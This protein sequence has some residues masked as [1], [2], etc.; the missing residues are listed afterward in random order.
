MRTRVNAPLVAGLSITVFGLLCLN[1]TTDGKADDHR[2]W[3]RE[4]G[5][6]EPG[7]GIYLLGLS[8]AVGGAGLAG[9]VIGRRRASGPA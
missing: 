1:Y 7:D 3:A 4:H 6:P 2:E 9:Y 5:I 8:G